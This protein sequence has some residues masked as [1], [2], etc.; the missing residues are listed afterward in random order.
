MK[1]KNPQMFQ[2]VE[3]ARQNQNN[4][5]ELFKQITNGKSPE[6]MEG[7][8]KRIEQMGFPSDVINQLKDINTK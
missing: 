6:Q 5:L 8:Y 1:A 7:F 3:Q 2:M 4:P